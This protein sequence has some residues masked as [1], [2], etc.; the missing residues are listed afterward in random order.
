MTNAKVHKG[1][2]DDKKV[3]KHCS[4]FNKSSD[5]YQKQTQSSSEQ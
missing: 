4:T 1:Y 5:I 3:K 2:R